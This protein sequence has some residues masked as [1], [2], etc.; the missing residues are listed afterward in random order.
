M[1]RSLL[2]V[3]NG[4]GEDMIGA[5]IISAL[6]RHDLTVTAY[7]LV[8]QGLYPPDV[9][10]LSPRQE[11]PSGGFSLRAGLRGL[12]SDLAA[13]IVRL[14]FD[15]RR[16]L[17]GQRG[18]HDLVVA[19]G[20]A[21][22]LWMATASA[23]RPVFVATADSVRTGGFG[24]AAR[25]AMRR[26]ARRI[27]ARDHD[28]ARVLAAEGLPAAALGNVM[29]DLVHVRGEAFGLSPDEPVI[30][31]LPGSRRE[32]P[33]NA[34]RLARAAAL[35]AESAPHARFLIAVPPTVSEERL[36]AGLASLSGAAESEPDVIGR[37]HIQLTPAFGDAVARACIVIGMAG[38]AHEQAA[39][40]GRPVIAFP[41]S[42]AQF[43]P[44]FL[45][46]QHQ[47]LGDALVPTR[48]YREA[49]AAALR[50]L[51]DPI[52]RE[53]RGAIGRQRIGGPGGAAAIARGIESMLDDH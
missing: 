8:G 26:H 10:L 7:P 29:M 44:E 25:W 28:T 50:L 38:T 46:T 15:Q 17:R 22:C 33:E 23:A 21:Y 45:R 41:G 24:R 31:L 48:D 32:S 30:T 42:G 14:W 2:F 51:G 40:L 47:L 43:G 37:A 3:S 35:I 19:V 4:I 49:A 34:A 27:F 12:R 5:R 13:G 52:E 1:G 53:R 36:R 39:G 20:D 11:L 18:R 16:T 9:L 6:E